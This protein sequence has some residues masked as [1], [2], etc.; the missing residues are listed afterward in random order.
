MAWL[1]ESFPSHVRLTSVAIGYN[2][3]QA[4]IGGSSPALATHLTTKYG[5]HSPGFIISAVAIVSMIGLHLQPKPEVRSSRANAVLA[6]LTVGGVGSGEEMEGEDVAEGVREGRRGE[7]IGMF[8]Y[9]SEM[10][11]I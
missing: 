5:N 9:G 8:D 2:L 11:M 3:S 1:V 10:E 7:K 4:L 6:D